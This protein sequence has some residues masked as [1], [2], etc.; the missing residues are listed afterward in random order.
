MKKFLVP[1]I[2]L[3]AFVVGSAMAADLPIRKA[4][5]L[6][7]APVVYDWSG[8]YIGGH[9]GWGFG[10]TD[11]TD[12]TVLGLN[13]LIPTQ[14]FNSDGF[15]G[16]VQAGWN[17]QVGNFVL[18]AE[19]DYSFAD[20][21]GDVTTTIGATDVSRSSNVMWIA[22]STARLGY[23]WD[24]VMIYSKL[25]AAFAQFDYNNNISVGGAS[26]FSTSASETRVG[27]TVGTGIEW[28]FAGGW[29]AKAEYNY[30]DFGRR[31]V[32]FGVDAA[33]NPVNL[34][35]DQRISVVKAGVNY[36]FAP[37]LKY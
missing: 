29:S 14:S 31:T 3:S 16:G 34:D 18:G 27:F 20:I 28:A 9:V 11:I 19:A 13:N 26:I 15:L 1:S 17:Y 35:V 7:P 10:E 2:V 23:A 25:G 32:D 5:S 21:K 37:L 6:P 30:M 12:R 22:T 33:G 24:R 8:I 36:R 4:P